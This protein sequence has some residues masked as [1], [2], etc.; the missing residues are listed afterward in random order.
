MNNGWKT[1]GR[2]AAGGILAAAL[3]AGI[4]PVP[5]SA[6]ADQAVDLYLD[7]EKSD[8]SARIV[9][10]AA[11]LPLDS[12]GA[13]GAKTVAD[14]DGKTYTVFAGKKELEFSVGTSGVRI[15][16]KLHTSNGSAMNIGTTV[17]VPLSWVSEPLNVK[18]VED[19]FTS[20]V[21]VFRAKEGSA[22]PAST[23]GAASAVRPQ[24]GAASAKPS[25]G[26]SAAQQP[27]Q[28]AVGQPAGQPAASG[29]G[30]GAPASNGGSTKPLSNQ[31]PATNSPSAV[32]ISNALPLLAGI[33]VDDQTVSIETTGATT[34][35]SFQLKSPDRIVVDLEGATVERAADGSASGTIAVDPNH[36][37]VA[38]VRYSLFAIE[39]ST[40]RVVIDLKQPKPFRMVAA[41]DGSGVLVRFDG[42]VAGDSGPR[43]PIRVMIDAGHGGTDPGAISVNGR[44]EKDL[45]LPVALKVAER[46]AAE[47]MIEPLLARSGDT[48][49]APS[50]RA[51]LA[52][53]QQVDLFISI[54]A[55]TASSPSVAGTETYYWRDDSAAF[56][57]TIHESLLGAIGSNDR[58]VK[59][60][61]FVVVRETTMP[62]AL[63]ELGFISNPADEAKLYD[64]QMQ[65]RIA[66]AIVAAIKTY[67]SIP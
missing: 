14:Q 11:Y 61:R 40:V 10:G 26:K 15:D 30:S 3:L 65:N 24:S 57:Q 34:P 53:A 59:K 12:L 13:F 54:H 32:V 47:P 29:Q 6:A 28:Q 20:S 66:D 9:D 45:T 35:K 22:A 41:D 1:F 44:Y 42:A 31:T 23:G 25:D 62:A 43:K 38:G 36:P 55:N 18:Y 19:R 8:T 21:Y 51:A 63:L 17:Y 67:Y 39:P 5:A 4:S 56:A 27:V 52:N 37:I 60:E 16:G 64:D 7:G 2:I 33:T 50:E 58:K 46:L 48:Y 49:L